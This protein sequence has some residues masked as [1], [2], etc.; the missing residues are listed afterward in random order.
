MVFALAEEHRPLPAAVVE[1]S[2]PS[3]IP[4][5]PDKAV[6]LRPFRTCRR[7]SPARLL[8]GREHTKNIFRRNHAQ[9]GRHT[10]RTKFSCL[11]ETLPGLG[12]RAREWLWTVL[13]DK[14]WGRQRRSSPLIAPYAQIRQ[15]SPANS[16]F[17]RMSIGGH[18]TQFTWFYGGLSGPIVK[19]TPSCLRRWPTTGKKVVGAR[20]ALAAEHAHQ[21]LRA[22][23]KLF[24]QLLEADRG[25]DVV[26]QQELCRSRCRCSGRLRSPHGRGRAEKAGSRCARAWIVSL[27]SRVSA[28][29]VS[30]R[31]RRTSPRTALSH[32]R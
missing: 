21:A 27:K 12:G 7:V 18:S 26:A 17:S 22:L 11:P 23:V 2:N 30:W 19:A 5:V 8:H 6:L 16:G 4:R 14:A 29:S 31:D 1:P 28:I 15:L 13:G 24:A 9:L 3:D 20:V 25:V 10:F 32:L